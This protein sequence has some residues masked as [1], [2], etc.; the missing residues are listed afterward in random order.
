MFANLGTTFRIGS[1]ELTMYYS[2]PDLRILMKAKSPFISAIGIFDN[3]TVANG[4]DT[5][6]WVRRTIGALRA[7]TAQL[8][9]DAQGTRTTWVRYASML[10]AFIKGTD[11]AGDIFIR[12]HYAWWYPKWVDMW[13]AAIQ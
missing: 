6:A 2:E 3:H 9:D 12:H 7:A 1:E 4:Q 13:R 10:N 8:A 5:D 11:D